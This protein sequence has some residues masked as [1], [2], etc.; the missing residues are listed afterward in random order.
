MPIVVACQKSNEVSWTY[1][2][3]CL[4]GCKTSMP[5]P[6]STILSVDIMI[7]FGHHHISETPSGKATQELNQTEATNKNIS[8]R[9]FLLGC[10]YLCK[11]RQR[12]RASQK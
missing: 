6:V 7:F 1:C 11:Y 8:E 9:K 4:R 3:S 10:L 12:N 2:T 5:C